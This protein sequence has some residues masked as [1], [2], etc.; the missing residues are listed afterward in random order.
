[1]FEALTPTDVAKV[2]E[3][4][5]SQVAEHYFKTERCRATEA[6]R[7]PYPPC[8]SN[9]VDSSSFGFASDFRLLAGMALGSLTT[10]VAKTIYEMAHQKGMKRAK[11]TR[12]QAQRTYGADGG[13]TGKIRHLGRKC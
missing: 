13:N 1:V 7:S 5:A 6:E 12:A 10:S 3:A 8:L 9:L 4:I 11:D 2:A